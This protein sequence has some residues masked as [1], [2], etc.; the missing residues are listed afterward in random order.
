VQKGWKKAK[1]VAKSTSSDGDWINDFRWTEEAQLVKFL[2][3]EPMSYKQHWVERQGKRGF[4]CLDQDCPLC[5]VGVKATPKH[6]FSVLVLDD[7]PKVYL[8]VVGN[9]DLGQLA[10]LDSNPKVGPLTRPYWSLSKSGTGPQTV[11]SFVPV[12]ERDLEEDWDISPE[13]AL[14]F[15]D[16]VEP[17]DESAIVI[18]SYADLKAIA[19]ALS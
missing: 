4:V 10:D 7:N 9:R 15:V 11:H 2:S 19:S 12:K 13:E 16:S 17:A 14:E 8:L 1:E 3:S 18:T 6:A 5:D